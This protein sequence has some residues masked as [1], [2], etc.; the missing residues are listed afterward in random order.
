MMEYLLINNK[1]YS[2]SKNYKENEELR[3]KYNKLTEKT[4]GF[5]FESWY[6]DGCWSENH[7]PYTLF[8]EGSAVSNISVNKMKF[9]ILKEEKKCLQLGTVMTDENFRN[10]GLGSYLMKR[11]IDE[12]KTEYDFIYLFANNTVLDFYPKFGFRKLTEYD[13]FKEIKSLR[14]ESSAKKIKMDTAENKKFLYEKVKKSKALFKIS[15][16]ENPELVMFYCTSYMKDFVYYIETLDTVVIA[17][18]NDNKLHIYDIFTSKN[19]EL[20]TIINFMY[21]PEIKKVTLGF[22]PYE[23]SFEKLRNSDK[24]NTLF[25]YGNSEVI[26]DI[27]KLKFPDLSHT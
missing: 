19:V 3:K 12:F 8:Y 21:K 24:E 1:E 13:S 10:Q 26:F 4:Y 2:F 18:Y 25:V 16:L 6:K 22:T 20:D 23:S 5:S 9:S 7:I 17:E 27:K 14:A 15:M 11:V